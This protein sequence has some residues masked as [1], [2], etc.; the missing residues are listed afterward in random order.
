[1]ARKCKFLKQID[2]NLEF[3][4]FMRLPVDSVKRK[5]LKSLEVIRE[6]KLTADEY[7]VYCG[8]QCK[9]SNEIWKCLRS[10]AFLIISEDKWLSLAFVTCIYGVPGQYETTYYGAWKTR[11][12]FDDWFKGVEN[13]YD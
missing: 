5:Y 2:N 9:F 7:F 13:D 8:A 6:I 4:I 10:R 12:S 11:K 3:N 1:M